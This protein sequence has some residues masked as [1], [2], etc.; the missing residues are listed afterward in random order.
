MI[1]IGGIYNRN[2]A[3]APQ[4]DHKNS[5]CDTTYSP[6]RLLDTSTYS[7]Q[8][9]FTPDVTPYMVPPVVYNIIGGG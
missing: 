2:A 3:T 4:G 5:V 6:I 9:E 1:V 7:W 8:T